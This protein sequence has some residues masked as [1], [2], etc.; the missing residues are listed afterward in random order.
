LPQVEGWHLAAHYRPARAVGGDFYDFIDMEDGRLGLVVGDVT[1]KGVPAALV[2][3]TTR[4]VLRAAAANLIEP[5]AVLKQVNTKLCPD[6]PPNMFVTCLFAVLD[7]ITG[8]MVYAN[9]GHDAPYQRSENGV[10]ELRARGMPLG[11]MPDMEYEEMETEL[12]AGDAILFYSDGLVEAHNVDREMFSFPRLHDLMGSQHTTT[13]EELVDF[14]LQQLADFT[15][16]GWE[17]EDDITLVTLQR[18]QNVARYTSFA[19]EMD[20]E[21]KATPAAAEIL[22]ST[23]SPET[24]ETLA[25]FTV[26]SERGNERVAIERVRSAVQSLNLPEPVLENLNTAVGEATMNAMEHG[27]KYSADLPVTLKVEAADSAIRVGITDQGGPIP[28]ES[29]EPD[30][31]LKLAGLQ[32]PRGWGLF[33]IKNMVDDV[34]VVDDDSGHTL[35]LIIHRKGD[36]DAE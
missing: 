17:Q 21:S 28:T 9:A 18:V 11:L 14:L 29:E 13:P 16:P 26:A 19:A 30:I 33:L 6:I 15:G 10:T 35:E 22:T 31:E 12:R 25:E 27:N 5:G 8:R 23:S 34:R 7:P 32:S 3:A 36:V 20:N 24:W 1:D 2:M 4:S